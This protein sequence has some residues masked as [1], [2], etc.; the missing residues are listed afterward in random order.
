MQ[1][2][3]Y[4]SRNDRMIGGVA[5]G[6]AEY[7]DI[8][9]VIVRIIFVCTL[10][11]GA[12]ILAYI[13]LW[14]IIPEEPFTFE[15]N[16]T[17]EQLSTS[18]QSS[19]SKNKSTLENESETNEKKPHDNKRTSYIFGGILV[20]LGVI[21]LFSNFVSFDAFWPLVF[22]ALGVALLLRTRN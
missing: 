15:N 17:S 7:F 21:L 14:I 22:I 12:G 11:F 10:F 18:E 9:P 6:I 13:L 4:R 19:T 16:S 3:W 1:K 2:K 8:D 5:G 20:V